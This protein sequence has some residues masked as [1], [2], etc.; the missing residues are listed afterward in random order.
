MLPTESSSWPPRH[1][2]VRF[3]FIGKSVNTIAWLWMWNSFFFIQVTR[4]LRNR[5]SPGFWADRNTTKH[6]RNYSL[7]TTEHSVRIK[8]YISGIKMNG[9]M[10][11]PFNVTLKIRLRVPIFRVN[12]SAQGRRVADLRSRWAG[13]PS[14]VPLIPSLENKLA[15]GGV[16]RWANEAISR[17]NKSNLF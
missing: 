17:I 10:N 4:N 12:L 3:L 14:G 11:Y 7:T 13:P 15:T 6:M 1:D 2:G 16:K 8:S 9:T 5:K